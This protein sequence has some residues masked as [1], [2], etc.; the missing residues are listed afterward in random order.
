MRLFCR[1]VLLASP[2]IITTGCHTHGPS[3]HKWEVW[4]AACKTYAHE[5]EVAE[6]IPG[7]SIFT[8]TGVSEDIAWP[9]GKVLKR[10]VAPGHVYVADVI[11][12]QWTGPVTD[13][14]CNA[15]SHASTCRFE[16]ADISAQLIETT[17]SGPVRTGIELLSRVFYDHARSLTLGSSS[18]LIMPAGES[19][20]GDAFNTIFWSKGPAETYV[21][22]GSGMGPQDVFDVTAWR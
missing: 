14:R 15:E 5:K 21:R 12:H 22:C 8:W 17:P 20:L 11:G 2:F 18:Y 3:E 13:A 16:E 7:R 1:L 10:F 9:G 19:T 6:K 4:R